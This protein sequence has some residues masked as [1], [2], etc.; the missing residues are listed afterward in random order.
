MTFEDEA[1]KVV[2]SPQPQSREFYD[3]YV[4]GCVPPLLAG[5]VVCLLTLLEGVFVLFELTGATDLNW[6]DGLNEVNPF[7]RLQFTCL[8]VLSTGD[9]F[10]S[11]GVGALGM[12]MCNN[13]LPDWFMYRANLKEVHAD[14]CNLLIKMFLFWRVLVT[15][16]IAPW[17]GVMLAFAPSTYDKSNC[18]VFV[19]LYI[20]LNIQSL[21]SLLAVQQVATYACQDMQNAIDAASTNER[22]QL[23]ERA[24]ADGF[25]T[26]MSPTRD[27]VIFGLLPLEPTVLAYVLL[28]SVACL[29]WAIEGRTAAGWAFLLEYQEV[30][31][32]KGFE[33]AVYSFSAVVTFL[34]M[35]ALLTFRQSRNELAYFMKEDA[36]MQNQYEHREEM[37]RLQRARKRS[38]SVLLACFIGN[39]LRVC[40]F[41]PITGMVLLFKNLCGFY[42]SGLSRVAFSKENSN[43]GSVHCAA[44]DW[45]IIVSVISIAAID[46]YLAWSVFWLWR[47]YRNE[48]PEVGGP[49]V[50]PRKLVGGMEN[51]GSSNTLDGRSYKLPLP[52]GSMSI[53]IAAP[54][55]DS[56][57][58]IPISAPV[59]YT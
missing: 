45:S 26:V 52:A 14:L 3:Y 41:I 11:I 53:P 13:P 6:F 35:V 25:D 39:L 2:A 28:L 23:I 58:S 44:E 24:Y 56:R 18:M 34:G 9:F 32:T 17:A 36:S 4:C 38:I 50:T 27:S 22:L 19:L 49:P 51:Y 7:E 33:R 47:T 8:W 16:L 43:R 48:L 30:A 1:S 55:P 21:W 31:L 20:G 57:R 12:Y 29:L 42:V 46:G 5:Q 40:L 15:I 54:A 10:F 37:D 59:I